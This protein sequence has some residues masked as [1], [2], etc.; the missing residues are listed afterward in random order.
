MAPKSKCDILKK[1]GKVKRI[2]H[3]SDIHIRNESCHREMYLKVFETLFNKMTKLKICKNDLIVITGDVMDNGKSLTPDAIEVAKIFY[4]RLSEYTDV[5]TILGNHDKRL[6]SDKDTLTP[7]VN[8]WFN[9]K[10]KLYFLLENKVYLYGNIAFVHTKFD[11]T[12]VTE[13]VGY[14]DY[15]KIALFH[16]IIHGCSFE[17][18]FVG[19]SQFNMTDFKHFDYCM[20]GD[21]HINKYVNKK[22][23]AWY[24][25]SLVAC[26]VSEDPF[27]HGGMLLD[28]DKGKSE[29]ILIENE[30]KKFDLVMNDDGE[31]QMKC[32]GKLIDCDIEELLKNTKDVDM[33]IVLSSSNK[34]HLDLMKKKFKD[35][36]TELKCATNYKKND[37]AFDAVVSMNGKIKKLSDVTNTNELITFLGYYVKNVHK[38]LDRQKIEKALHLL[39]DKDEQL[40][41]NKTIKFLKIE[42]NNIMRY[43]ENVIINLDEMKGVIGMCETN[44][45]GKSTLCEMLSIILH[46][47]TPRCNF[48]VSFIKKGKEECYGIV[49]LMI[50]EVEY[51]IKRIIRRRGASKRGK[52]NKDTVNKKDYDE[53]SIE[54]I[55]YTDKKND[56]Y[57]AF[58]NCRESLNSK[59]LFKKLSKAEDV[60]KIIDTEIISYEDIYKKVIVSQGRFGSFVKSQN[61]REELFNMTNMGYLSKIGDKSCGILTSLKTQ[62]TK[63]LN[64]ISDKFRNDK[65]VEIDI[66]QKKID[67]VTKNNENMINKNDALYKKIENEFN[68]S[69]QEIAR[70]EERLKNYQEFKEIDDVN[71]DKLK[72]INDELQK[73]IKSNEIDNMIAKMKNDEKE[74]KKIG[75]TMK[76]YGDMEKKK[77][78]F[79]EENKKNA[80]DLHGKINGLIKKLIKCDNVTKKQSDVSKKENEQLKKE[81]NI[82]ENNIE[83]IQYVIKLSSNKDVFEN[84]KIYFDLFNELC[85]YEKEM[86]AINDIS[87]EL[88]EKIKDKNALLV[89]KNIIDEKKTEI[90]HMT[91]KI[92][93]N[94]VKYQKYKDD[95][96]LYDPS[97]DV[98]NDL[99]N[100]EEEK[101]VIIKKIKNNT[102]IIQNYENTLMNND[103]NKEINVF[104]KEIL[105][106]ESSVLDNYDAFYELT[107][108]CTELEKKINMQKID[109]EKAKSKN[110]KNLLELHKNENILQKIQ[111]DKEKYKIY[112][113]TKKAHIKLINDHKKIKE[114]FDKIKQEKNKCDNDVKKINSLIMIANLTLEKCKEIDESIDIL[115]IVKNSLCVNGLVDTM[116]SEKILPS[117]RQ[118]VNE[119]CEYSG[120]DPINIDMVLPSSTSKNNKYEI[121]VSTE[122]CPNIS[123]VGGFQSN[124]IDLIFALAFLQIGGKKFEC[125][126]IIIDELF[127]AASNQ[128]KHIAIRLLEYFKS[129]YDKLLV[130]SHNDDIIQTFDHRLCIKNEK[131]GAKLMF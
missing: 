72:N 12:V 29:F 112:C 9:S 66:I 122:A 89:I 34:K 44:S 88:L 2:L 8:E 87:D 103:I 85:F 60:Q 116:M 92:Q 13:C 90:I 70:Y 49:R 115:E 125:D 129:C 18:G 53:T 118:I 22:E 25:G 30:S 128:N 6:D 83:K 76:K 7:I 131:S 39:I 3:L 5:I 28:V 86:E 51:M 67:D 114:Q 100:A 111:N 59:I 55:K 35:S 4:Y 19:R 37:V 65:C 71:I 126:L 21:V 81:L 27:R 47:R 31:L 96:E 110:E 120:H 17:N 79:D 94:I 36:G 57:D 82:I 127:D 46:G 40:V 41:L 56:K 14:D 24:A 69:S 93:K 45:M 105:K 98:Y 75:I 42:I 64:E 121:V 68:N 50:G 38:N 52:N 113:E 119:M 16:G 20:F 15:V 1:D 63:L 74:L 102:N 10:N 26:S 99:D 97:E 32:K 23:T 43:G 61:K 54:I 91:S 62:K 130:V 124:I 109:I 33:R 123:N 107:K 101:N 106:I 58:T 104:E 73:N 95:Y 108:K 80:T 117:L 78:K 11:S 48:P 84:Y 77:K